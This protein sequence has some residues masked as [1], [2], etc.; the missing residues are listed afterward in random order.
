MI[1]QALRIVLEE[2]EI[3]AKLREGLSAAGQLKDLSFGLVPGTVKIGGK[4]QVGF[5]IPFDTEWTVGV[6]EQ[7]RRLGVRLAKVSVG[8]LGMSTSMA[9]TQIM[10]ALAQKLQGVTG[11]AVE[12]DTILLE[13]ALLLAAKGVRLD[14]PVKRID[15]IDGRVEIEIG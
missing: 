6:M 13:P 14:A 3:A 9:S 4:F 12:Q 1:I 2:A 8:M 10:S 15:V 11:V 5:S 7:G